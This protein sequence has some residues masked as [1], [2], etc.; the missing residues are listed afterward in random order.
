MNDNSIIHDIILWIYYII[1]NNSLYHLMNI[2]SFLISFYKNMNNISFMIS[3]YKCL[4]Y[5]MIS[6]YKW[7]YN[8][9][10]IVFHDIILYNIMKIISFIM[11]SF[12]KTMKLMI[13][14]NILWYSWYHSYKNMINIYHMISF[15]DKYDNL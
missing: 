15:Y 4:W 3:F 9:S 11:T 13:H 5:F 7:M 1:H 12:I 6:F 2:T 14:N 10:L 8:L